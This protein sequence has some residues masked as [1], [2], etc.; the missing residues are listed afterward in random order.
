LFAPTQ[1]M[2]AQFARRSR[3]RRDF[4]RE[5]VIAHIASK[6]EGVAIPDLDQDFGWARST[7]RRAVADARSRNR[8]RINE[9]GDLVAIEG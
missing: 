8:L 3:Q 5:L 2:V 4:L 7:T 1:G 6:P 9:H